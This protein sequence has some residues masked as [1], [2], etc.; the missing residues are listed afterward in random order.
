M[1]PGTTIEGR[2]AIRSTWET[3]MRAMEWVVP[4][5]GVC[6]FEV[7][8]A[9]GTPPRRVTIDERYS[10]TKGGPGGILATYTDEYRRVNGHWLFATRTLHVIHAF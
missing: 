1:K 7:D 6:V 10:R 2:D 4:T 3:A 5:P 8:E 9:E